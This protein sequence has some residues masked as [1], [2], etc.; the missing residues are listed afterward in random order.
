MLQCS[1]VC[2][3]S[4]CDCM[5]GLTDSAPSEALRELRAPLAEALEGVQQDQDR[6]RTSAAAEALSGLL[7]SS[8]S[9]AGKWRDV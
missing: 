1:M 6:P 2:S 8:S 4:E 9:Y 3:I 7:A 5:Q